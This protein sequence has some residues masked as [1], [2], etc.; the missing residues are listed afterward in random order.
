MLKNTNEVIIAIRLLKSNMQSLLLP[1]IN[2]IYLFL[3]Q[4]S[5]PTLFKYALVTPL[6]KNIICL[7]RKYTDGLSS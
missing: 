2:L 7:F 5:F 6:L 3:T 4:G 1:I